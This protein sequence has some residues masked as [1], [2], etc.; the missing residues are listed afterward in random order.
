MFAALKE[1]GEQARGV[2]S[3]PIPAVG[4]RLAQSRDYIVLMTRRTGLRAKRVWFLISYS[5]AA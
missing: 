1:P 2:L 4:V 5:Y 3:A